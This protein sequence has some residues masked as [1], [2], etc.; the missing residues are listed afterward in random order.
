MARAACAK[1]TG[2]RLPCPRHVHPKLTMIDRDSAQ[3]IADAYVR[4]VGWRYGVS[5]V[6]R[7]GEVGRPPTLYNGPDMW[8]CWLAYVDMRGSGWLGPSTVILINK[9][10]GE[11]LYAGGA[12]DEG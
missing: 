6:R 9:E 7:V 5:E 3:A 4:G 11:V 12:N 1:G 10:T 2:S 8:R